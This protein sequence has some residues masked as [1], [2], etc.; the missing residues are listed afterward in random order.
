MKRR[1]IL[2]V[3]LLLGVV[4][5]SGCGDPDKA[6][7]KALSDEMVELDETFEEIL[8]SEEEELTEKSIIEDAEKW[9]EDAEEMGDEFSSLYGTKVKESDIDQVLS[10]L[11]TESETMESFILE[12]KTK[13]VEAFIAD[14]EQV[15]D[16]IWAFDNENITDGYIEEENRETCLA[17]ADQ[18]DEYIG[19][20]ETYLGIIDADKAEALEA[21]LDTASL[22][23]RSF[24]YMSC[25]KDILIDYSYE[26]QLMA[27][28]GQ[29]SSFNSS[30]YKT[31][32]QQQKEVYDS[33]SYR[34]G[35]DMKETLESV[36][37]IV[38]YM[39]NTVYY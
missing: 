34:L 27:G 4:M 20:L 28:L 39:V 14:C 17:M 12:C 15:V 8:S 38:E 32:L 18:A 2:V 21:S 3:V 7:F 36:Y 19:E 33:F 23:V 37:E 30:P 29:L 22:Y 24:D 6:E 26:T 5:L 9:I 35:S 31:R 1:L 10:H 16:D 11:E 25:L 13:Q